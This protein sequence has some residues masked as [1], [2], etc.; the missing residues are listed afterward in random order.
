MTQLGIFAAGWDQI[1]MAVIPKLAD[2][3][4]ISR[5]LFRGQTIRAVWAC[6]DCGSN[7]GHIG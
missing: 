1:A 2:P 4:R 3:S 5:T 7:R 6:R